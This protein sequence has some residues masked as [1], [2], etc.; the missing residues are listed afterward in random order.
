MRPWFRQRAHL[1]LRAP[2]P[3]R[4]KDEDISQPAK[5]CCLSLVSRLGS[6]NKK[7]CCVFCSGSQGR[8]RGWHLHSPPETSPL[9]P[10]KHLFPAS[11]QAD[12]MLGPPTGVPPTTTNTNLIPQATTVAFGAGSDY[13]KTKL[14]PEL[15][16]QLSCFICL[17]SVLS[18]ESDIIQVI[19]SDSFIPSNGVHTFNRKYWI[20]KLKKGFLRWNIYVL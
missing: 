1:G 5:D 15:H 13:L 9:P 7:I 14:I 11:L 17:Y 10:L 12:W 8:L 4:I 16:Q 2:S 19:W 3:P 18:Q 6:F 20:K